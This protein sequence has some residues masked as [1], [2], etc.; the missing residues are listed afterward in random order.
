MLGQL[1]NKISKF[2]DKYAGGPIAATGI[3]PNK[4][5]VLALPL[6]AIAAYF[7]YAHNWPV[8]L[9]VMAL[10]IFIDNLDGSVARAQKTVSKWGG[11]WD[12]M[13]D[14]HVEMIIYL[15]FA[16]GGY[17][18]LAFLAATLTMLNSYAKPSVALRIPI[19]NADWPAIGERADRLLILLV[20]IFV[21]VFY[22][23]LY[24]IDTVQLTLLAVVA[25]CL[26]GDMQRMLFA[27]KLFA[28][29]A[30][31]KKKQMVRH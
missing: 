29:Y 16:L 2:L 12:V 20:G 6:A 11:Y 19:G 13:V 27:K 15:G 31:T 22:P 24:G 4:V 10:S 18:L 17:Q 3:H 9:A 8:A 28:N 5:T 23:A 26:V 14:K 30:R 21:A 7:V 1:R 25:A